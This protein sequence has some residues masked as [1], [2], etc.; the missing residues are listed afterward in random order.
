[1]HEVVEMN[2]NSRKLLAAGAIYLKLNAKAVK[3]SERTINQF[4]V[5]T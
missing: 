5:K 1:M 4:V 2:K 3:R